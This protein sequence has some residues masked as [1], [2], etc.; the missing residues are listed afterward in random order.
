MW[1]CGILSWYPYTIQQILPCTA[2]TGSCCRWLLQVVAAGGCS[3]LPYRRC[4]AGFCWRRRGWWVCVTLSPGDLSGRGSLP[5]PDIHLPSAS[6]AS[7]SDL[8][9]SVNQWQW[10]V[11][12]RSY[13][14]HL[15]RVTYLT[16]LVNLSCCWLTKLSISNL[17]GF[18][19]LKRFSKASLKVMLP[20][21]ALFVL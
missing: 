2:I 17:D 12:G 10:W 14:S 20:P 19:I 1:S 18:K 8:C 3:G 7:L 4:G 9:N 13:H 15:R 16:P 21:M 6:A 11:Q 5:I